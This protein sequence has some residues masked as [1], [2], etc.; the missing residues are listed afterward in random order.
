[1]AVAE[2]VRRGLE[3]RAVDY[4][5]GAQELEVVL[6][7]ARHAGPVLDQGHLQRVRRGSGDRKARLA[8]FLVSRCESR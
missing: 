7:Q 1:M 2:L 6:P 8:W 5:S 3:V 4:E